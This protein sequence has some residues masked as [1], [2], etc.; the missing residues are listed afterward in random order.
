MFLGVS[1]ALGRAASSMRVDFNNS[2][3]CSGSNSISPALSSDERNDK[4]C[5]GG[6][7]LLLQTTKELLVIPRPELRSVYT[8]A[9]VLVQYMYEPEYKQVR[10]RK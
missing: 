7:T 4:L 6:R 1:D 5:V 3:R 2:T 10:S 8:I 9:L